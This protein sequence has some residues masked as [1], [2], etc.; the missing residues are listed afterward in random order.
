MSKNDIIYN[1]VVSVTQEYFGP[2]ADRYV[3][4]Q[5]RNHLNKNPQQLRKQDLMGLIDWMG[6]TMALLID[7]ETIINKYIK[8]LKELLRPASLKA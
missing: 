8:D 1:E 2:A 7:D 4:R 3:V 6:L 5:I